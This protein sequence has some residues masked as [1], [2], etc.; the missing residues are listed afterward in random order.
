MKRLSYNYLVLA[1]L[2]PIAAINNCTTTE[3]TSSVEGVPPGKPEVRAKD[4]AVIY[5]CRTE[6]Q[7]A[8]QQ[9]RIDP[10][11]DFIDEW[12]D[13]GFFKERNREIFG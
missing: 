6:G 7:V 4:V 8:A 10:N 1:A 3:Q 11:G 2:L 13:G 9:L 5:V 12:P